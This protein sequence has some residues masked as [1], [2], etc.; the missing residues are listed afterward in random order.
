MWVV[1]GERER[2]GGPTVQVSVVE[3]TK[4]NIFIH[5]FIQPKHAS[6]PQ[7]LAV[8]NGSQAEERRRSVQRRKEPGFTAYHPVTISRV[9][10]LTKLQASQGGSFLKAPGSQHLQPSVCLLLNW[11]LG[12]KEKGPSCSVAGCRF[13]LKMGLNLTQKQRLSSRVGEGEH[14]RG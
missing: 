12:Q 6:N 1:L 11:A 2:K 4:Q 9:P 8:Q 10:G 3:T 14:K 7:E 13:P 5:E